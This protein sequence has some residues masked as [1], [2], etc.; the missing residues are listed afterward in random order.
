ME[1]LKEE[2]HDDT[3]MPILV[4]MEPAT[5]AKPINRPKTHS[6]LGSLLGT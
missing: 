2:R 6:T 4:L 1:Q 5:A 3:T